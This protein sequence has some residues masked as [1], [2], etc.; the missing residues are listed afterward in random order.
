MG[1]DDRARREGF[2]AQQWNAFQAGQVRNERVVL[3]I[4]FGEPRL[5]KIPSVVH[6]KPTSQ[7]GCME[8][9]C[10]VSPQGMLAVGR[11]R[12]RRDGHHGLACKAQ[13]TSEERVARV[14]RQSQEDGEWKN[15]CVQFE[16]QEEDAKP[17]ENGS[18]GGC[19]KDRFEDSIERRN[20]EQSADAPAWFN[21]VSLSRTSKFLEFQCGRR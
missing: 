1:A 18:M 2:Q 3:S 21:S 7:Q 20:A 15:Q 8:S 4:L 11:R 17:D 6:A 13:W 10:M 12:L 19:A 5:V 9:M 14:A 16:E